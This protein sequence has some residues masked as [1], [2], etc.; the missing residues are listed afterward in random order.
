MRCASRRAAKPSRT[1]AGRRSPLRHGVPTAGA[2]T[3]RFAHAD[4]DVRARSP[5]V[6]LGAAHRARQQDERRPAGD[7]WREDGLVFTTEI[8]TA[9]EPQNVLRRFEQPSA[10]THTHVVQEQLGHSSYAIT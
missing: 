9:L 10:G 2:L 1:R 6:G 3:W 5:L 7:D 8:G 4:M